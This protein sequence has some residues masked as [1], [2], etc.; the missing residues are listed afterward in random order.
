MRVGCW[1]CRGA[2]T[3]AAKQGRGG[4]GPARRRRVGRAGWPDSFLGSRPGS[5]R[6]GTACVALT[7]PRKAFAT[8]RPLHGKRKGG[9]TAVRVQLVCC[10]QRRTVSSAA[11]VG[12]AGVA[13]Q[14]PAGQDVRGHQP[15]PRG[16]PSKVEASHA[17]GLGTRSL[18]IC[19]G[20]RWGSLTSNQGRPAKSGGGDTQ[21]RAKEGTRHT[22]S[23]PLTCVSRYL[24]P[25]GGM[26]YNYHTLPRHEP[27]AHCPPSHAGRC[28]TP[29]AW[30]DPPGWP[31]REDRRRSL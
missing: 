21:P 1:R 5:G 6:P 31:A 20:A 7:A 24:G 13:L 30:A 3:R 10:A 11:T 23:D 8:A 15:S 18:P 28:E 4:W 26:H 9:S 2:R 29:D 22:L 14:R 25:P 19:A 16:G 27:A 12:V 17:L